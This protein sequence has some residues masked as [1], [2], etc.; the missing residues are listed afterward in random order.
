MR[1]RTPALPTTDVALRRPPA[2]Q[3]VARWGGLLCLVGLVVV[4]ALT[5]GAPV[6][7]SDLWSS[8]TEKVDVART[9][10]LSLRPSRA[11]AGLLVGATLAVSGSTLQSVFRNPLAEPYLLGISAG[12]AL[13]AAIGLALQKSIA[14]GFEPTAVF[15]CVGALAASAAV[16]VLGGRAASPEIRDGGFDRSRLLLVGVA[17]SAF[18]AAAMAL[19]VTLSNRADIAQQV[20]FWTLGGLSD[21]TPSQLIFLTFALVVGMGLVLLNARDLNA[22]RAGDEDAQS[23]GVDVSTLHKR[24]LFAAALMSAAAVSAAGLVGFVG[25][26]APHLVRQVFG[27]DAR[28]LVPASALGGAALLCGCDALARSVVRPVEIPVGIVTALLGVP[29]FLWLARKA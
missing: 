27:N 20:L 23:L 28:T 22:L 9:I 29:L 8:D 5:L 13:G 25:L 18:L 26:L 1:E 2:R 7:F 21:T 17:L 3:I 10:F 6:P 19:V 11:L 4:A 16:Y 14:F 24:L 15:A 12:G